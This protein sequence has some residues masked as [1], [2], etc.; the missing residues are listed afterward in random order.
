M[1]LQCSWAGLLEVRLS[2]GGCEMVQIHG[3]HERDLVVPDSAFNQREH[4]GSWENL[5]EFLRLFVANTTEM[6]D[7][8]AHDV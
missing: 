7:P 6:N 8:V 3:L 2:N 1:Q 5:A 4:S